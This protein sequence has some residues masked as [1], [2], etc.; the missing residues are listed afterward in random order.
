M[1]MKTVVSKTAKENQQDRRDVMIKLR[2]K[3]HK[4]YINE[5]K[6]HYIKLTKGKKYIK[7]ALYLPDGADF[8]ISG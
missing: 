7:D 2:E 3:R 6:N 5:V 4:Q 1:D 8:R